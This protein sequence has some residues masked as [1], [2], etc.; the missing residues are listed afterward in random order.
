MRKIVKTLF[1]LVIITGATFIVLNNFKINSVICQSQFSKCNP[2]L[3]K[4]LDSVPKR[5]LKKTRKDLLSLLK[6]DP[7]IEKYKMQLDLRGS[8]IIKVQERE[9]KYC[10]KKG[11]INY[12]SDLSGFIFKSDSVNSTRCIHAENFDRGVGNYFT[13][14]EISALK[15]IY[16]LR[17]ISE[18]T[19][20]VLQNDIFTVEY[21]GNIK[22]IFS[23]DKVDEDLIAG[24]VYYIASQFDIIKEYI[25]KNGYDE[26]YE[27]DFRYNN[28][29]VRLI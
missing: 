29:V 19:E 2:D 21:K 28:P 11:D 1:L 20:A 22:L 17:N 16:K 27:I 7:T 8:Y 9:A 13:D 6:N 23:L 5:N 10:L 18:I 4:R 15:I 25:I 14:N 3:Q 24:K 12:Y 26:V